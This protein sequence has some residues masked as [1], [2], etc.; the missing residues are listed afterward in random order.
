MAV[1]AK[2]KA[3]EGTNSTDES[4]YDRI[5]DVDQH[6]TFITKFC[7]LMVAGT[8]ASI[9]QTFTFFALC[10]SAS[11]GLHDALFSSIMRAKMSFFDS[12]PSGRILNRF[13]KDLKNIDSQ[14]AQALIQ[15]ISVSRNH[16]VME[17][18][19]HI[20]LSLYLE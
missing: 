3:F 8:I 2:I 5:A 6:S 4:D 20:F 17:L 11:I 7:G 9:Y 18:F 19:S 14:L 1:G 12:T 10:L 13:S 16:L 15:F